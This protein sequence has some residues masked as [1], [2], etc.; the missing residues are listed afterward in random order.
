[1]HE[2]LLQV[3][4]DLATLNSN[5]PM[6]LRQIRREASTKRTTGV[7]VDRHRNIVVGD[8]DRFIDRFM[9]NHDQAI[10]AV[11]VHPPM[12]FAFLRLHMDLFVIGS[13][14]E[15]QYR[16]DACVHNG[17]AITI[18]PRNGFHRGCE[19][20]NGAFGAGCIPKDPAR[21]PFGLGQ[22]LF[23]A[24]GF[25]SE[26]GREESEV[27]VAADR[28]DFAA[29]FNKLIE[30]FDHQVRRWSLGEEISGQDKSPDAFTVQEVLGE[31][32]ELNP[33]SMYVPDDCRCT[34]HEGIFD[35][36]P[37]ICS[38]DSI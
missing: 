17:H 6:V 11:V 29:G 10:T 22:I 19:P 38:L 4:W 13:S 26:L 28:H 16:I 37:H 36:T 5:E 23:R 30:F 3:A 14:I 7:D 27:V 18:G 24:T 25:Q 34:V 15:A 35:T 8:T 2:V 31:F 9:T 1:M 33:A 12:S 32:D 21:S 20:V